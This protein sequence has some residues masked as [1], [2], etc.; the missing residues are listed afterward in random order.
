MDVLIEYELIGGPRDGSVVKSPH[1]LPVGYSFWIARG[2][3]MMDQYKSW[4]SYRTQRVVLVF[5]RTELI[6]DCECN[7]CEEGGREES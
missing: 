3:K 2:D 4:V 1:F 7:G 5:E 6:P